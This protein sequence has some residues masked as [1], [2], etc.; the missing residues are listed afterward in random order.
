MVRFPMEPPVPLLPRAA[1][2][3]EKFPVLPST[4]PFTVATPI[5]LA[6]DGDLADRARGGN[7][8]TRLGIPSDE[9]RADEERSNFSKRRAGHRELG[10]DDVTSHFEC[11]DRA[12]DVADEIRRASGSAETSERKRA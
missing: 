4:A 10:V 12:A 11:A 7:L 2:F 1:I 8:S 3:P 6:A 5:K 9:R